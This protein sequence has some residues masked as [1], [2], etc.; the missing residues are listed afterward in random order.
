M[1][2]LHDHY[3]ILGLSP[4]ATLDQVKQ[5]YLKLARQWH[6]DRFVE[7][8]QQQQ[9][10]EEKFKAISHA[11]DQIRSV[12]ASPAYSPRVQNQIKDD[13]DALYQEATR[14]VEDND[15]QLAIEALTQAIRL[16]PDYLKAYQYRAFLN[17]QLGYIHRAA[18]DF[19]KVQELKGSAPQSRASGSTAASQPAQPDPAPPSITHWQQVR[20]LRGHSQAITRVIYSPDGKMLVSGSQDKTIKLWP[21]DGGR[22]RYT[23]PGYEGPV[24]DLSLR[25]EGQTVI[26]AC[27]DK[28]LR[29][30]DLSSRKMHRL[31]RMGAHSGPILTVAFSPDGEKVIS[32][33][34]DRT[35][36]LWQFSTGKVLTTVEGYSEPL[37]LIAVSPTGTTFITNGEGKTARIRSIQTGQSLRWLSLDSPLRVATFSPD[38]QQI[39]TATTTR[40]ILW[41]VN[42]AQ[43]IHDLSG[44]T[45]PISALAFSPRG[46]LLAASCGSQI[47]LWQVETGEPL[48]CLSEGHERI[49]SLAW[50]PNGEELLGGRGDGSIQ[51]WH[52]QG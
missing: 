2:T 47:K 3:Q 9:V 38:G 14:C 20:V 50:H 16:R 11:Y 48:P 19:K 5:A 42:S 49:T 33:G 51:V 12:L 6:P 4:G 46:D 52:P 15:L 34:V 8:P 27:G 32:A 36:K 18:S 41:Q 21:L 25:R 17:E 37:S 1:P 35:V 10:A 23:L 44:E 22:I 39:A 28:V 24:H 30:W 45:R 31:G 29:W 40:L 13:P 43:P 26:A 7:D